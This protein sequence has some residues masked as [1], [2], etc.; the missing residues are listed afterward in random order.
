MHMHVSKDSDVP[1]RQQVAAQLEFRIATR[2]LQPGDALPSVRSLARQLSVHHNTVSQ[3]YQDLV[4]K[5][6]LVRRPGVEWSS[7][8]RK[9][10]CIRRPTATWTI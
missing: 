8:T 1:L 6:F 4:Q 5:L 7:A 10:P 2:R 9:R 3:A